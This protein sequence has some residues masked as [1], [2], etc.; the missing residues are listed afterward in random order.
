VESIIFGKAL[1]FAAAFV[2][3]LQLAFGLTAGLRLIIG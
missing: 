3:K 1:E 2:T